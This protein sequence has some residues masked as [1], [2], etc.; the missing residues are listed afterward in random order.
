MNFKF[1]D[2]VQT[3]GRKV[4]YLGHAQYCGVRYHLVHYGLRSNEGWSIP[5]NPAS[6]QVM[7][8]QLLNK[9]TCLGFT[10]N[11]YWVSDVRRCA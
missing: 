9:V 10:T 6:A 1:G 3:L 11:L 4:T 7:S 2:K 8:K 5:N